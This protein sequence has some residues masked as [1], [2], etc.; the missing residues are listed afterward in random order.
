MSISY[1]QFLL[2]LKIIVMVGF[3]LFNLPQITLSLDEY[4]DNQIKDPRL[5]NTEEICED[6][7]KMR[8]YL[9]NGG[10]PN[11]R[12]NLLHGMHSG[13]GDWYYS[14]PLVCS[15]IQSDEDTVKILIEKGAELDYM[16]HSNYSPVLFTALDKAIEIGNIKITKLLIDAGAKINLSEEELIDSGREAPIFIAVKNGHREI[17]KLLISYQVNL[18]IQDVS[19]NTVF[20]YAKDRVILDLLNK[21]NASN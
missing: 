17:V 16:A 14:T 4:F 13:G 11:L 1:A 18:D 7:K 19:G 10:D 20:D 6:A 8:F 3:L 21:Y 12:I 15:V 2:Q 9:Q 5:K